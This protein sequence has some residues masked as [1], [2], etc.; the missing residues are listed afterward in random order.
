LPPGARH[1]I[2]IFTQAED[3][4][5]WIARIPEWVVD[6]RIVAEAERENLQPVVL[7]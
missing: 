4:Q 7:W 6:G 5:R 2:D 1:L 3:F